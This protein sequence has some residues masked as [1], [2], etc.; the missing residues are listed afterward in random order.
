[1]LAP[2]MALLGYAPNFSGMTVNFPT[3]VD[4]KDDEMLVI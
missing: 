1:M 2:A 3:G 4:P